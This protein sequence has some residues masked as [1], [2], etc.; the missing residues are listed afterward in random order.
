MADK[1]IKIRGE[2]VAV[3]EEVYYI[4]HHM[5]RQRRTQ[6]EKDGRRRVASYDALDT[7]DGLGIDLLVDEASPGVEEA[8]I[9]RIMSEKLH[10]CLAL[11][12]ERDRSLLEK[13]YFEEMS[14]RQVAQIIGIPQKTLHDR[15]IRALR[16]LRKMMV[17]Q[18]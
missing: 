6:A 8:V 4:Y 7:N 11:L 1:H 13:I 10:R 14:E 12:P 3:T 17:R 16:K 15:K 2:L 18:K 5:G 9:A